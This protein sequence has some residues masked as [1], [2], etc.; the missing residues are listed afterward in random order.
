MPPDLDAARLE[1]TARERSGLDDLGPPTYRDGFDRL[2]DDLTHD[3]HLSPQGEAVAPEVLVG[4]LVNRL[5]VVDWHRRHPELADQ[6]VAAPVFMIGMGR[7]GTT[8]LHDLLAQ[9][10]ANR[11]PRTWEVDKPIPPPETATYDTDPRIDEVQ[12]SI[13]VMDSL[14]PEFKTMHPTGARLAQECIRMTGSEFASLIFLSQ[15]RLPAY[16]DWLTNRADLAPAYRWH[17]RYLQLLQSRHH[18][19]RWVLKSGAHLWA[20]PALVGEYPDATMIQTHR[21]PV[22]AIASLSSLFATVRAIAS[23]DVSIPQVA[24]DWADAMLD[25]LD[26]GVAARED[27]TIPAGRGV[28][29][30][31]QEFLADPLGTIGG[32]YDAWGV[33][34]TPAAKARMQAFLAENRQ[35]QHGPHRYSLADTGLDEGELR[36]KARRYTDYFDVPA[37]PAR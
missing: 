33:E 37:E 5:Q 13:A 10:P 14:N 34:L 29:V 16:Q 26:R 35:D 22:K 4:Y 25:A 9:D 28:D 2:L 36:E 18:G 17:R 6:P 20:L 11:V 8:I 1:A 30:Q 19:D 24:G 32:I 21:D 27:G 31:Y 12:A 7:T 15:F 3:A 23:D